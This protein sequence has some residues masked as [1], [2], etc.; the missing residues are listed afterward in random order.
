MPEERGQ[1]Q[2]SAVIKTVTDLVQVL[3]IQII[4]MSTGWNR[5]QYGK[6]QGKGDKNGQWTEPVCVT[7]RLEAV[8]HAFLYSR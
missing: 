1:N 4:V 8:L 3:S 5:N 6:K 2:I 7:T